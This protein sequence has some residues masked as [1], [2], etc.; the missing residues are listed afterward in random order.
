MTEKETPSG[1]ADELRRRAV[2]VVRSRDSQMPENLDELSP[3]AVRQMLQELW[4]HQVELEMQNEE[5]RR[6]QEQLEGS[7]ARYFDLYDLAPVGYVT[8]SEKGLILEANL[9]F[10]ALL[11]LTRGELVKQPLTHFVFR[12]DQDI[13]YRHRQHFFATGESQAYEI[14]MVRPKDSPFWARVEATAAL[15]DDGAKVCRVVVSDISEHKRS[16]AKKDELEDQYRQTQKAQSLGRMAGAIAHHFNNQLQV[17]IGNLELAL[18]DL[19]P[20]KGPVKNLK[21]ARQAADQ[22]AEVSKVMLTY[23]GQSPGER[24]PLDL[25]E[26]CRRGLIMLRAARPK[27]V[28]LEIDFPVPGPVISANAN[29]LQQVLTNLVTNAWEAAEGVQATISIRLTIKTV[30]SADIPVAHRVPTGWQPEDRSYAC[31]EV[32]DTCCG[33]EDQDMENIFD[34][35]FSTKFTGRGLGLPVV[36]GIV[37]AHHGVVVVES[38][39]GRRST[40]RVF[41]PLTAQKVPRP[42]DREAKPREM[43]KGGTML[44]VEDE[45]LLRELVAIMLTRLGFTVLQAKDGVE[46]VEVF[47]QHQDEIRCVLCDLIMPRLDGWATLNALRQLKPGIPVILASGYDESEVMTGEHPEWPQV[48]LE[49][50]FEFQGLRSAISQAL[51]TKTEGK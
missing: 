40:F 6:A 10:A 42:P 45:E 12:E 20:D 21:A 4:V 34:P 25:S 19:S 2:E 22:A 23:L 49:K 7:Q 16:D 41:L 38:E 32:A 30:S 17:V 28:V 11:G 29:L 3:E 47:R 33:I 39:P 13:Y 14:R 31:L 46:G 5:L 9:T 43:V 24:E 50:P 35:F 51:I 44:L 36:L 8:L 37:R 48:F 1:V 18:C 15:D 27:D 26:T